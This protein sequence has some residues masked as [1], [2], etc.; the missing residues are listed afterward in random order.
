MSGGVGR[1]RLDSDSDYRDMRRNRFGV[2]LV[3]LPGS[4]AL[5]KADAELNRRV[6]IA[7]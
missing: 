5:S 2:D 6:K 7:T 3:P 4:L 1:V